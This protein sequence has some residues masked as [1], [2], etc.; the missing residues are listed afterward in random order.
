[1]KVSKVIFTSISVLVLLVAGIVF[2]VSIPWTTLF[3]GIILSPAPPKPEVTYA[4]F[5]FEIVYEIDGETFTVND[6]YICEFGGIGANEGQGKYRQWNGYVKKTR[7]EGLFLTKID[8]RKIY[9]S[10]GSPEYYMSDP[11]YTGYP[12][13]EPHL[14]DVSDNDKFDFSLEAFENILQ[15][16]NINIISYKLSEPI[17]NEYK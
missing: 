12:S 13:H 2:F 17:E 4:E 10:V 7:E 11:D 6:V 15:E 3:A 5:P 1:M 9:C 8:G 14:Y 16:H